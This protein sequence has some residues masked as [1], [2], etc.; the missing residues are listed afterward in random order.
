MFADLS[1]NYQLDSTSHFGSLSQNKTDNEYD[2]I[3]H[4]Q[5]G[6]T[7]IPGL[8]SIFL[9]KS[10]FLVSETH[11]LVASQIRSIFLGSTYEKG[12]NH[13]QFITWE[14][15]PTRVPRTAAG[16]GAA[17]QVLRAMDGI[18]SWTSLGNLG[19]ADITSL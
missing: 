17:S 13:H 18:G 9:V 8:S 5:T 12:T 14:P 4:T 19:P 7:V 16:S 1:A 11:F 2:R 6:Q 15:P 10:P 3:Q